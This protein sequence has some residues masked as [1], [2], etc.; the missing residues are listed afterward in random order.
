MDG[1]DAGATAVGE[2]AVARLLA[3]VGYGPRGTAPDT[4]TWIH[5]DGRF[6]VGALTGRWAKPAAEYIGE[7]AREEAR[8][9]RIAV[10][11]AELAALATEAAA[12]TTEAQAVAA[13]RRTLDAELAAAP[14]DAPLRQAHARLDAAAQQTGRAARR[15]DERAADLTETAQRAER[16]AA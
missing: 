6:R 8:R 5:S 16:A 2:Q 10:L 12:I 15:R 7:G 14:D 9:A 3:A 11:R 4:D 1:G 13:R